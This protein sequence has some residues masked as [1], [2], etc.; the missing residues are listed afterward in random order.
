MK[1][2]NSM[3]TILVLVIAATTLALGSVPQITK[4]FFSFEPQANA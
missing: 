1:S 3:T 4:S 2:R